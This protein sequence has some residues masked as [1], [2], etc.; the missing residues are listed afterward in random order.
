MDLSLERIEAAAEK[1]DPVFLDSPQFIDERLSAEFGREVLVKVE[2]LNPIGS[3]KGRGTWLL[4]QELDPKRTWVCAT[5]GNFG[6]GLAYAARARG[7]RVQVFASADAPPAKLE[8]MRALGARVEVRE[9][10]GSAAREHASESDERVLVVD[11]KDPSIAEGAAT[12]GVELGSAG[13]IDTAVVQIGDGAL[14]SGVA[15]WLKS[16][17]P[18]T[19]IVGVCASGAPA[20]ARSFAA[21]RAISVEGAGTIAA[22]LAINDPVPESLARVTELVDVIVLVDDDELRSSIELVAESLGLLV[23]PAGAAGIAALAR[24]G[25]SLQGRRVAVVLTGAGTPS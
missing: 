10:P 6:Q 15:R 18:R 19:R 13:P 21:G 24:H 5:A 23:E 12:I 1:I 4:A 25:A 16:R 17:D 11:G 22:A 20:M 8:R 14:I 2:T 7:A 3:F 9:R